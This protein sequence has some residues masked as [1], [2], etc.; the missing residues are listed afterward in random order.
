MVKVKCND[1]RPCDFCERCRHS[2]FHEAN[3]MCNL[4]YC[5]TLGIQKN[6]HGAAICQSTGNTATNWMSEKI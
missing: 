1:Y 3:P 5:P 4:A 6:A 2:E